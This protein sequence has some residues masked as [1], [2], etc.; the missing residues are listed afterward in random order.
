MFG[1]NLKDFHLPT[2]PNELTNFV[3]D[4]SDKAGSALNSVKKQSKRLTSK[5]IPNGESDKSGEKEKGTSEK[6]I[7]FLTLAGITEIDVEFGGVMELPGSYTTEY[8]R[9]CKDIIEYDTLVQQYIDQLRK[10]DAGSIKAYHKIGSLLNYNESHNGIFVKRNAKIGCTP[11]HIP[12]KLQRR[13]KKVG[14]KCR[15]TRECIGKKTKCIKP[16]QGKYIAGTCEERKF[17]GEGKVC[18]KT[19]DCPQG[20]VCDKEKCT[21]KLDR[22][23]NLKDAAKGDKG[24]LAV[25]LKELSGIRG[26]KF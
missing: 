25:E 8:K 3:G 11:H 6:P 18:K 15:N 4:I 14:E 5:I 7:D 2:L 12:L 24:K 20:L 19:D 1:V 9:P 17:K 23:K 16:L 21:R 10:D 26:E 13:T 22:E